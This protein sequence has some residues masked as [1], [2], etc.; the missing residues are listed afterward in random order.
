MQLLVNGLIT[1]SQIVLLGCGFFL[2]LSVARFFNFAHASIYLLGPYLALGF[3]EHLGLHLGVACGLG[4]IVAS[5][6]GVFLDASVFRPLA[7]RK[8]S[9]LILL[10]ASLVSGR[11]AGQGDREVPHG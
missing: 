4:I 2:I 10:L 9:S 8:A 1:A 5:A 11:N 3:A 7:R 6:T